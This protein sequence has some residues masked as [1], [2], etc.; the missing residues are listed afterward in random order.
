MSS[1]PQQQWST[2]K[3]F[4]FSTG[5]WNLHSGA[6]PFGPTVRPE[7]DFVEKLKTFKELGF[8]YVQF[9]DD[10]AVPDDYMPVERHE[11][12]IAELRAEI[13][14]QKAAAAYAVCIAFSESIFRS[15]EK[16]E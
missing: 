4:K 16:S 6:D 7:R 8:D 2:K 3:D 12:V 11:A 9:H 14:E 1:Q 10:D 15:L 5:P 13:E